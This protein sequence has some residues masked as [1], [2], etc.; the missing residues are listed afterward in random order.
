VFWV[1]VILLTYAAIRAMIAE[2]EA[3]LTAREVAATEAASPP[4]HAPVG[5]DT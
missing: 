5:E 1:A 2:E 4:S 3:R